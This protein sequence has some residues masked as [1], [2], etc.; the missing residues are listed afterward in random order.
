MRPRARTM[1]RIRSSKGPT[2]TWR[3]GM[4]HR[5]MEL[6]GMELKGMELRLSGTEAA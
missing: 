3:R 2:L 1:K 4:E 5:G 6:R